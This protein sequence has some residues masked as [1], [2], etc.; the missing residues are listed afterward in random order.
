[1]PMGRVGS[2]RHWVAPVAIAL[3]GVGVSCVAFWFADRLDDARVR[4]ELSYRVDWRTRDIQ[5][6]LRLAGNPVEDVAIAAAVDSELS[7][8]QF[9]RVAQ[10]AQ[11]G[12]EYV[13]GLQ[14]APRIRREDI[15]SFEAKARAQGLSGYRVFDV[16]REFQPTALTP[17]EEYFPVLYDSRTD[18][19]S[20]GLALGRFEGRRVPMERAR[21]DGNAVATMPVQPIGPRSTELIYLLFW[22][23]YDGLEEPDSVNERRARFRGFAI[24]NFN[25]RVLLDESVRGTPEI[26]A[27]IRF[28]IAAA[29]QSDALSTA[30]AVYTPATGRVTTGAVPP[31]AAA[32]AYRL[33][34]EVSVFGQHWDI[35]FDYPPEVFA[36]MR[37]GVAWGW[38]VAGLLLTGSLVYYVARERNRREQIVELVAVRTAELQRTSAQLQQAQKMESI[39]NLSGGIAHDFNNLLMVVIGNLELLGEVV[40]ANPAA[41]AF[42]DAA[43]EASERGAELTRRLLAFARRQPLDPKVTDVNALVSGMTRLLARLVEA[44]IKMTL[45]TGPNVWP[46]MIDPAQLDSAIANLVNNARDAM[47]DGG[48]LTIETRNTHL[49]ADYAA[50]NPEVVPGDYVLIQVTDTGV[51]MSAEVLGQA[52]EPFFTTKQPGSGTGLGLSMVFGFVKQSQGHIKIYS[53]AGQ[54]TTV[55]LYLP[56]FGGSAVPGAKTSAAGAATEVSDEVILLVEDTLEVRRVMATQISGLGYKVLEAESGPAAL[57]ILSDPTVHIDLLFTDLVMPG[58]MTGRELALTARTLRPG[59]KVLFTSGYPGNSLRDADRL[60]TSEM[61]IAKPFGKQELARKLRE[62][63]DA[64]V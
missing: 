26:F 16:T 36:S 64:K 41:R 8:E 62:C 5:A 17:R 45:I 54:G 44:H 59:L 2:P 10:H 55:R 23:V 63:L 14:W 61:F 25:L 20:V 22:P 7:A 11:R 38:L 4:T 6:K 58:G 60:K 49:D 42:V 57:A 18:S 47:P 30:V 48:T 3:I 28:S 33:A 51:G 46:V 40:E 50:A 43:M 13:N 37:S 12:V 52:F 35:T 39:G 27:T 1:M 19:P 24:G 34:R 9:V 56:R 21:D 53:E 32:V 29:H 31:P 15:P